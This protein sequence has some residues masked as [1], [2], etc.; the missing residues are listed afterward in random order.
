M[1]APPGTSTTARRRGGASA[2]GA[3]GARRRDVGGDDALL[4]L[5]TCARATAKDSNK[6]LLVQ[7]VATATRAS[8]AQ[9]FG[10]ADVALERLSKHELDVFIEVA[11]DDVREKFH[12]HG[13]A[14]GDSKWTR[15]YV[16]K[17]LKFDRLKGARRDRDH[18]TV[19]SQLC[20]MRGQAPDG[21]LFVLELGCGTKQFERVR[22]A[23]ENEIVVITVDIDESRQPTWVEDIR[24]W[25]H[26]L[27]RRLDSLR[28]TYSDFSNFHYVHFSPQ[29]TE[30]SC[31]KSTGVRKVGK[32]LELVLHGMM[33][34]LD[35][36]PPI[37]TIECS[38][39]GAHRLANQAIMRG[40]APRL[41][42][43]TFCKCVDR[44]GNKKPSAWWCSFPR[45]LVR[46][47]FQPLVC[48]ADNPCLGRSLTKLF[49]G[50]PGRHFSTSQSGRSA[51][52]VP[53]MKRDDAMAFPRGLVTA[54][55]HMVVV[56]LAHPDSYRDR[57]MKIDRWRFK[58]TL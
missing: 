18:K 8:V 27:P 22:G 43:F 34:I 9:F 17:E 50:G 14:H 44:R 39:S 2:R 3:D 5:A 49:A 30:L 40:L 32:A 48:T 46:K 6:R 56:W 26:W 57:V 1:R 37:W 29:C 55:L 41:H 25:R 15:M 33:L 47:Y 35:I 20:A 51:S 53:G 36:K 31:S 58:S 54:I 12:V 24:Q 28:K 45:T 52:G 16:S 7:R 42:E 19:A 23:W 13:H 21:R 38:H 10:D 11:F 4:A